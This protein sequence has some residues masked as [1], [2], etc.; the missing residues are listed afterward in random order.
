M[1]KSLRLFS[2]TALTAAAAL[3]L[4]ACAASPAPASPPD[5]SE[6]T[7]AAEAEAAAGREFVNGRLV[8]DV[9]LYERISV[10]NDKGDVVELFDEIIEALDSPAESVPLPHDAMFHVFDELN[11]QLLDESGEARTDVNMIAGILEH[12]DN[13]GI[14]VV[15]TPHPEA[16]EP[17][18][19]TDQ[20]KFDVTFLGSLVRPDDPLLLDFSFLQ[21]IP[22]ADEAAASGIELLAQRIEAGQTYTFGEE[23]DDGEILPWA[24]SRVLGAAVVGST[25][26]TGPAKGR[27]SDPYMDGFKGGLR[28]CIGK[29]GVGCVRNFFKKSA[30]GARG[31]NDLLR[32]NLCIGDCN[33]PPR[34]PREN[35][36]CFYNCKPPAR[37]WGDPHMVTFDGVTIDMHLVGEFVLARG[38]GL[39]VQARTEPMD[40][41]NGSISTISMAA[42][43]LDGHTIAVE[44]AAGA[45]RVWV[46]GSEATAEDDLIT[47]VELDGLNVVIEAR[48]VAIFATDSDVGVVIDVSHFTQPLL[49]VSIFAPEEAAE[50]VGLLGDNDGDPANDLRARDGTVVAADAATSEFYTDFADTW[51][52]ESGESI[53]YYRDGET[54]DTFT[55]RDYPNPD[56]AGPSPAELRR[57]EM[58]CHAA[59]VTDPH[60]LAGC[61]FD[62]AVSGSVEFVRA[63]QLLGSVEERVATLV[64]L[65]TAELLNDGAA[66]DGDR[67]DDD[68][69]ALAWSRTMWHSPDEVVHYCPPLNRE[70]GGWRV[71]GGQDGVYSHDSSVCMAAVHAGLITFE[72]GGTIEVTRQPGL[73]EYVGSTR[74]G[75]TTLDWGSW[76]ASYTLARHE[77]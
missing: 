54:T 60:L 47:T 66:R 61:A 22:A 57:G 71:W 41:S 69:V 48:S 77:P 33:P 44:P 72:G 40:A 35:P 29:T 62:Y 56:A 51:R 26:A 75:V 5:E 18:G 70:P 43:H 10:V 34:P 52:V 39:E 55:E 25:A 64:G 74:N 76:H 27:I 50:F 59:G 7:A 42:V 20:V 13:V 63:A 17:I 58:L 28:S 11:P 37:F 1:E 2:A 9:W 30:N 6:P 31:S 8:Q 24:F 45:P 12:D 14:A 21:A 68:D 38:H 49:N 15:G 73:D 32:E 19:P 36:R 23:A 65:A 16:T 3:I 67:I 4:S 53:L 46:N